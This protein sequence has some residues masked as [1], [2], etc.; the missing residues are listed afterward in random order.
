MHLAQVA[1]RGSAWHCG[2]GQSQRLLE[3][4]A[5]ARIVAQSPERP[6]PLPMACRLSPH[7][8]GHSRLGNRCLGCRLGQR[9]VA[10]HLGIICPAE[11]HLG[12]PGRVAQGDSQ[13]VECG[14]ILSLGEALAQ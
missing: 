13:P 4:P 1:P 5:A 7:V 2:L 8:A 12:L 11:R 10:R 9:I 14:Q 3:L 6:A